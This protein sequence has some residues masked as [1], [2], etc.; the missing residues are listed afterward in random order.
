MLGQD[1][2]RGRIVDLSWEVVP[3]GTEERPFRI[4]R[5][6]LADRA[7]KHEVITHTH[8]GTHVEVPAHFFEGGKEVTDLP[9]DRFFGRGVL[10]DVPDAVEA[11]DIGPEWL[12]RNLKPLLQKDDIIICRNSDARTRQ[13]EAT[14]EDPGLTV[15]GAEW[16]RHQG[17][18]MVG[19]DDHFRFGND[20]EEGRAIHDVLMSADICLIEFLANL[21]ALKR[22]E[23][24]FIALPFKARG[25]DSAWTRA[26][27]VEEP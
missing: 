21:A 3:P 17:V 19:I 23:F 5:G 12:E 27:A 10:L 2:L 26:I 11:R 18:K 22:S 6:L 20:V 13:P 15:A 4:T 14:V 7:F 24:F 16:L 9:L 8:V 25:V 1:L